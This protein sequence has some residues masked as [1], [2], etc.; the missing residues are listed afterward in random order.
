MRGCCLCLAFFILLI[1]ICF[2]IPALVY[3]FRYYVIEIDELSHSLFAIRRGNLDTAKEFSAQDS[4]FELNGLRFQNNG[5]VDDSGIYVEDRALIISFNETVS[6]RR[7]K[8]ENIHLDPSF[9][10]TPVTPAQAKWIGKLLCHILNKP[11]REWNY[12]VPWEKFLK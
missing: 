2:A 8:V 3:L 6:L 4:D 9:Y 5:S 1:A 12:A 7:G 10:I 11:P